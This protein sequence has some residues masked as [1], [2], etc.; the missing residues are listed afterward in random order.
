MA[1]CWLREACRAKEEQG[2]PRSCVILNR[3]YDASQSVASTCCIIY[4]ESNPILFF[5]QASPRFA[6]LVPVIPLEALRTVETSVS[7]TELSALASYILIHVKYVRQL[8]HPYLRRW[9][10]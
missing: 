10:H 2:K 7:F 6:I 8:A 4:H 5:K 9:L 1:C 3:I